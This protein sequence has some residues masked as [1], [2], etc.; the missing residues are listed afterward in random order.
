MKQLTFIIS[1]IFFV[2]AA[3][4]QSVQDLFHSSETKITW[5]GIDYSHVKL[6]GDF[7]LFAEWGEYSPSEIKQYYFPAWNDLIYS[8]S[9]KYDVAEMIRKEI[10]VFKTDAIY[11][12]NAN[13]SIEDMEAKTDPMYSKEDIQTFIKK[14]DFQVKEGIG[15]LL[16]AESLNKYKEYGKFH[17]VAIDLSNNT[18]LLHDIIQGKPG[19]IGLRNYWARTV[20]NVISEIK[21]HRYSKWKNESKHS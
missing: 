7:T 17:F 13:A 14:Y 4:S 10:L 2:N 20:F 11:T 9:D 16:V 1:I 18:V 12:I 6:I 19:G 15:V 3:K 5:L 21:S 8:E